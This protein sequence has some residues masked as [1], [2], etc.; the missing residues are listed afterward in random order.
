[1]QVLSS[2]FLRQSEIVWRC[3]PRFLDEAVQQDNLLIHLGKERSG[4]AISQART[5]FPNVVA[6]IVH[7]RFSDRPRY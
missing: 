4:D 2:S 1:L 6:Q 7:E 3:F 5:G